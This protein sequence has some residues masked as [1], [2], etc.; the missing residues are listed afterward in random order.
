MHTLFPSWPVFPWSFP[1]RLRREGSIR[2]ERHI[3]A[4]TLQQYLFVIHWRD[5]KCGSCLGKND[6]SNDVPVFLQVLGEGCGGLVCSREILVLSPHHRVRCFLPLCLSILLCCCFW[7]AW[8]LLLWWPVRPQDLLW[9][10]HPGQGDCISYR[11]SSRGPPRLADCPG[12][13]ICKLNCRAAGQCK[14]QQSKCPQNLLLLRLLLG[15]AVLV[16]CRR[17]FVACATNRFLVLSST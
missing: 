14:L 7:R 15:G 17:L 13:A 6:L 8:C 9:Q 1:V 10:T 12:S 4:A 5:C 16:W 3:A 2:T 11:D